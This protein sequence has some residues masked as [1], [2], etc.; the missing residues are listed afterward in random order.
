MIWEDAQFISVIETLPHAAKA[1]E[2]KDMAAAVAIP[3]QNLSNFFNF[4]SRSLI[5]PR[6]LY[7]GETEGM[8][9]YARIL[10]GCII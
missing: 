9:G 5:L 2:A 7:T 10:Y 4:F 3:A 8:E 6:R 1:G